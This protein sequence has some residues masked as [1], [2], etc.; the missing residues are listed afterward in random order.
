MYLTLKVLFAFILF[1]ALVLTV[2]F[3]GPMVVG[4]RILKFFNITL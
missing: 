4:E 2:A 1:A 3:I